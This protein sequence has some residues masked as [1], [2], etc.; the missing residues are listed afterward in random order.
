MGIEPPL[1]IVEAL[2]KARADG[3]YRVLAE[4]TNSSVDF[5]SNDYLGLS[6]E[7]A[8]SIN[9]TELLSETEG[10]IGATGSRL[11]SGTTESHVL[12]EEKLAQFF[13]AEAALFFGSGYEANLGLMSCIASRGD[14]II[15]DKNIHASMRDGIRLSQARSYSFRHN[16]LE[17]LRRKVENAHG[18]VFVAVESLYSMDGDKAPLDGLFR[19]SQ[20]MGFK[21]VVDEAHSTGIFGS[22]GEG[23][24]CEYGHAEICF[25]RVHTF[26]KAA[27]Y[28]GACIVGD[29]TLKEYLVNFSRPFIY[30]TAPD[31]ITVALI[32]EVLVLLRAATDRRAQL[33]SNIALWGE[34]AGATRQADYFR[35]ES[36]VQVFKIAGNE[37][38]MAAQEFLERSSLL[39]KGIRSPTVPEGT[40]RIRICLH[41]F[42]STDDIR[43]LWKLLVN[44]FLT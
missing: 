15:F 18:E 42:N 4:T 20:E 2:K 32:Q 12:L 33:M 17:D 1:H 34:L 5:C 21:L 43:R 35:Q 11:V 29:A 8:L 39:V 24:V 25:A 13:R 19:L 31:L 41:S 23:L 30:S 7:V 36:P 26:G 44:N 40:E 16:D 14:T 22:Y 6:K 9:F 28:K 3:R 27:G 38:V 10:Q 37:A